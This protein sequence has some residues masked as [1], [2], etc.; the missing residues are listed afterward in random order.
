MTVDSAR[1]PMEAAI[2]PTFEL[3]QPFAELS[4]EGLKELE[5][6]TVLRQLPEAVTRE[7]ERDMFVMRN[8]EVV[9]GKLY[10][11]AADG[12]SVS[13]DPLGGSSEADRRTVPSNQ[14][15]RIYIK[16]PKARSVYARVLNPGT[17]ATAA[18]SGSGGITITGPAN[19]LWT[20]TGITVRRGQSLSFN[21]SGEIQIVEGTGPERNAT[22]DGSASFTGS[23]TRYPLPAVPVG[24]LIGRV[25]NGAPFAIGSSTQP[26]P[27]SNNGR[28]FLGINDDQHADN[29]GSFTVVINR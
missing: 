14:I 18:T 4:P 19:R 8:G 23:R 16:A 22:P 7:H 11:I 3:A 21:A 12:T 17:P 15:A 29:S 25:G 26:I 24:T 13:F 1:I 6:I 28:L 10:H 5:Q 20:D 2:H 9:K 27:V